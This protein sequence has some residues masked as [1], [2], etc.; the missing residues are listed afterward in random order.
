MNPSNSSPLR[1]GGGKEFEDVCY[2]A[3]SG[4]FVRC[5]MVSLFAGASRSPRNPLEMDPQRPPDPPPPRTCKKIRG[6][7]GSSPPTQ[8]HSSKPHRYNQ[9][10]EAGGGG[11]WCPSP[12]AHACRT[13]N[14]ISLCAVS[15]SGMRQKHGLRK[16]GLRESS[17]AHAVAQ[18]CI[19]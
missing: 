9:P 5:L 7:R 1:G 17:G 8:S 13:C 14:A 11:A 10:R 16:V 19:S 6:G 18:I 2:V 15:R 4:C 3:D 12:L